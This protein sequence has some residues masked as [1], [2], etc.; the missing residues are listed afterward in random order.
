MLAT[1]LVCGVSKDKTL[2]TGIALADQ[3]LL[4]FKHPLSRPAL[5]DMVSSTLDELLPPDAHLRASNRLAISAT[6]L[7]KFESEVFSQFKTRQHLIDVVVASCFIPIWAGMS[8]PTIGKFK[9]LDGAYSNNTPEI[10]LSELDKKLGFRNII[11]GPFE[12]PDMHV[13]PILNRYLFRAK[14]MTSYYSCN[15]GNATRAFHSMVPRKPI[16]QSKYISEGYDSMKRFVLNE[17]LI[18]CKNCYKQI[19][20]QQFEIDNVDTSNTSNFKLVQQ[21]TSNQSSNRPCLE[22]L[23]L[24]EKVES[25]KIPESIL[26]ACEVTNQNVI[27]EAA[28]GASNCHAV[29]QIT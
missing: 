29:I 23:K 17:N 18:K 10:E 5:K 28:N 2:A 20:G 27:S 26:K 12:S 15:F 4:K 11:I 22:C 25:L 6:R 7:W 16:Y 21:T 8:Y 3:A 13:T 24:L 1:L 19:P 14:V 9:Y